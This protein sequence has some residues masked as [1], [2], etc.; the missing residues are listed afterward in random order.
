MFPMDNFHFPLVTPVSIAAA[1]ATT[2]SSLPSLA[3]LHSCLSHAPFSWVQQLTSRG[4]LDFV[5]KDNFDCTSYQLGKQV[6]FPFNNNELLSTSIFGL[7]HPN[8]WGPSP[9]ISIGGFRYFVVLI[10][11]H[12]H[13]S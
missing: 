9:I 7:I 13:Y 2:F 8:V 10:D 12:P 3:L 5:S 1:V 6:A 4:L 11:D